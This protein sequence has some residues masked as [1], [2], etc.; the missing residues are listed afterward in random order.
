MKMY[1]KPCLYFFIVC[2]FYHQQSSCQTHAIDSLKNQINKA[3][4][5]SKKLEAIFTLCTK[6]HSLATDT[7]YKYAS[8]AKT[9]SAAENNKH[10]IILADYYYLN[11]LIKKG[12]RDSALSICNTYIPALKNNSAENDLYLNFIGTKIGLLIKANQ[13]K[14]GFATCYLLLNE[15]E[16]RKDTL[17]QL[18]ALNDLGWINMEMDQNRRAIGFLNI[19][20]QNPACRNIEKYGEYVSFIYSNIA[21]AYS[22]IDK[23]DSALYFINKAILLARKFE[24]LTSLANSLA[25]KA[26][27]MSAT[28]RNK[29]AEDELIEVVNIR[30]QIGDP[31][32]IVSDMNQLAVYYYHNNQPQKGIAVSLEGIDMAIKNNLDSKLPLLYDG[33]AQNYYV[34]GDYKMYGETL[35]K[36][37]TLKDSL[38]KKNSAE[39]LAEI[40][41]KYEMQKKENII[42]TQ[43][44]DLIKKNYLLFGSLILFF[45]ITVSAI[46]L[47]RI[48]RKKQK[49]KL[50]FMMAEEKRLSHEAV[51]HAEE[52]ERKRIAADLHD[53]MGAYATAII[54]NVDD[55]VLSKKNDTEKALFNLKINAI[56][57]MSNLR[58]TI[59]AS[60]KEKILLTG[61]SDRFKSYIKKILSAYPHVHIEIFDKIDNDI[62]F[63]AIQ[64]LNIFRILQEACTNALKHSRASLIKV[65]FESNGMC[66]LSISDNGTGITDTSYL[67]NGN[68]IKNMKLRASE[69]GLC[70]SVEENEPT[71]TVIVLTSE[72]ILHT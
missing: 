5:N 70:L 1:R 60:Y 3:V 8:I 38:Y 19:A 34:A 55:I 14:E 11:Y 36:I 17:S 46:L 9:L 63:S 45:L 53:N 54:A 4:N 29:E 2:C 56:E 68:G 71:G 22:S 69:S 10:D 50:S 23:N 62:S 6:R 21:A 72:L 64:A 33:L 15:S 13:Y 52:K 27:I 48:Y 61:I 40:Q 49:M 18:L 7:L 32:F 37:I 66:K 44:L 57:L 51:I 25:I 30:K 28:N 31:F 47:F 39:A 67:N 26:D 58:D 43:H 65:V 24:N 20:L 42:V 16:K 35:K 12:Q 41:G 59:W